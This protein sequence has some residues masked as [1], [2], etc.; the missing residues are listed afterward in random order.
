M[1]RQVIAGGRTR[2]R[3]SARRRGRALERE[4]AVL[5]TVARVLG[6]VRRANRV[7]M[8]ERDEARDGLRLERDDA[9]EQLDFVAR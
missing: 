2:A 7:G 8:R 5:E 6:K 1:Q 4:M 3:S 9:V